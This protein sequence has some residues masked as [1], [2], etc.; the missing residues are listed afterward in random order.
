MIPVVAVMMHLGGQE[1]G[2][3]RRL[4]GKTVGSCHLNLLD[5]YDHT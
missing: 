4:R 2:G 5:A 3:M 1:D